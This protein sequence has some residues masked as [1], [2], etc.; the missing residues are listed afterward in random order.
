MADTPKN[1]FVGNKFKFTLTGSMFKDNEFDI[2]ITGMNIPGIQLGLINHG[3]HVRQ[4]ELPGDSI[5]F[6]DLSFE[7]IVSEDL[8]E[9]ITIYN[10]MQ[11]L[12]D[13]SIDKFDND[14]LSDGSLI[15]LTNK[16][17]PNVVLNFEGMFPYNLSDVPLS[18][19]VSD[20]EPV[21]C[22]A[23]FKYLDYKLLSNV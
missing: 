20:G 10:W 3:T 21:L 22:E 15:L 19:N 14:V 6:N 9:W 23:T 5:V 4:L 8:E 13:F 16:I 17:N 1:F 12:R 18:L 11:N 7:F 2:M